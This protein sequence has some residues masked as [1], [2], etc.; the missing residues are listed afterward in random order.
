VT[1]AEDGGG[2]SGGEKECGGSQWRLPTGTVVRLSSGGGTRHRTMAV[3]RCSDTKARQRGVGPRLSGRR[4]RLRTRRRGR[5]ALYG[6]GVALSARCGA[7]HT[8]WRQRADEWARRGGREAD[9]WDPA[10]DFI[11]N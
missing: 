6:V 2:E 1:C 11:P 9:M 4:Y 8:R 3:T 5:S 7:W 10:T